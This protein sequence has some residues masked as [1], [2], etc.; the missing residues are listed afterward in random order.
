MA[1]RNV[2][3]KYYKELPSHFFDDLSRKKIVVCI[4]LFIFLKK[5][6]K[7]TKTA[8]LLGIYKLALIFFF[9]ILPV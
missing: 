5:P 7:Q 8:F 1:R 9:F 2:L 6:Q 4:Y 3:E